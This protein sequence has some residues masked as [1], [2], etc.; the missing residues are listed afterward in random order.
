V[1]QAFL[2]ELWQL[3][4]DQAGMPVSLPDKKNPAKIDVGGNSIFAG[5]F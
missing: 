4:E 5:I 2:P 3:G 1:P